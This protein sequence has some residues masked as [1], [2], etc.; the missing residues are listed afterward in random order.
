MDQIRWTRLQRLFDEAMAMSSEQRSRFL[1][2]HCA[3]DPE[4]RAELMRLM[5]ASERSD[6]FMQDAVMSAIV[7]TLDEAP[8]D[9]QGRH[10]G[11]WEIERELGRG[12]MGAVYLASRADGEYRAKVAIKVLRSGLVSADALQR[13]RSERQILAQLDHPNIARFLGGGTTE[14]GW[15]YVVLEYIDG[16]PLDVYCDRKRLDVR[17]RIALFR[18][19]CSAVQYAHQSLVVHRDLKPGNILVTADG[20]PKLLDFGIAKILDPAFGPETLLQTHADVRPMTPAYAAPEQVMGQPVTT[21]TD[22]YALGVLLYQLLTGRPPLETPAGNAAEAQRIICDVT[23]PRP[24]EVVERPLAGSA[25]SSALDWTEGDRSG[26][27]PDR[28]VPATELARVRN[29]LPERLRRSLKGDL[30]TIVLTAVRKE[31]QRR[32]T[33]A[34]Q[35]EEDL[36]RFLMG[37]PVSAQPD[38]LG[39]R[40]RKFV[41][42]NK[43]GVAVAAGV[44]TLVVGS[45]LAISI[46]ADRIAEER[47]R[48]TR[49]SARAGFVADF[50][51]DLFEVSDPGEA[52][53]NSITAR[54]LLDRGA[55]RIETEFEGD[56]ATQ[57]SLMASIGRTYRNL[58]LFHE[59]KPVLERVVAL[60]AEVDGPDNLEDADAMSDLANL[61]YELGEYDRAYE[62]TEETLRIR[63][64]QTDGPSAGLALSLNDLG[65]LEYEKSNYEVATALHEEALAIREAVFE[66]PHLAIAESL[67]NLAAV[68]LDAGRLELAIERS[69]RAMAMRI[70]VLGEEHPVV[71]DAR[72]NLGT[73]YELTGDLEEA[74]RLFRLAVEGERAMRGPDD[75]LAAASLVNLGRLLAR[76]GQ[77]EEAESLYREAVRLDRLRGDDHPF[78]AY[79]LRHLGNLLRSEGR[80]EEARGILAEAQRIY[81]LADEPNSDLANVLTSLGLLE[82]SEGN[83]DRAEAHFRSAEATWSGILPPEHYRIHRLRTYIAQT[84]FDRGRLVEA[85]ALLEPAYELLLEHRGAENGDTRR[86]ANLLSE[87]RAQLDAAS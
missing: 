54:E 9:P 8:R 47:D 58:G 82:R 71:N 22:V 85:E 36:G 29:T 3:G 65:W 79:D 51:V 48:A 27:G 12:G 86:A 55:A 35:L 57:A 1:D 40:V 17:A 20:E 74:E 24:S 50:L 52:R 64:A 80:N 39:Y 78:V 69:Q 60:Q 31:P 14:D 67:N 11:P 62:L 38:T 15:P 84:L 46:Q 61:S 23:P 28:V 75:P 68:D 5:S 26:P 7:S 53:G 25:S 13:F 83:L 2:E 43:V 18:Q 45:A 77:V 30:D 59:S 33:S 37:R 19:V 10:I 32:Y 87:I 49:E 63:R 6:G 70:E 66:A 73:I 21:A 76:T 34:A 41:G 56:P 42:R 81:E 4:L 72:M 44:A 16:E